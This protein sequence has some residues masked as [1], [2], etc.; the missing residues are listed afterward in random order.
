MPNAQLITPFYKD[1][2]PIRHQENV[3]ALIHN[4]QER[5]FWRIVLVVDDVDYT[6][7]DVVL[8]PTVEV[9][10]QNGRPT[11]NDL[12][13]IANE[14]PIPCVSIIAN[15]DIYFNRDS[16]NLI[17]ATIN[18]ETCFALSR[19]D[20]DDS[21]GATL[22]DHWDSQDAWVF[23]GAIRAI[24]GSFYLGKPGCDNAIAHR[25][26]SAGYKVTNPSK[27]IKSYHI[28]LS[29][30]RNYTRAEGEIIEK[31]YKL[32]NPT[33]INEEI[34]SVSKG[35]VRQNI[36]LPTP[37]QLRE[38]YS[39]GV[40]KKQMAA[41]ATRMLKPRYLLA[42][43]IPTMWSRSGTFNK[44]I[45]ELNCQI[46][47]GRF[48]DKVIVRHKVDGGVLPIGA[49]RND[50]IMQADAKYVIFMDDDDMPSPDYVDQL[51][52]AIENGNHP[53]CVT[54]ECNVYSCVEGH[55][56]EYMMRMVYDINEKEG[57][58]HL[59]AG[60]GRLLRK[61]PGHLCAIKRKIMLNVPFN[62]LWGD[63][64]DRKRRG[65]NGT[66]VNQLLDLKQSGLI[67]SAVHINKVLYHYYYNPQK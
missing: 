33:F 17:E 23:Y 50:L 27:S 5:V 44:L 10:Y 35:N 2:N 29:G 16:I 43:L 8:P 32:I 47:D 1:K 59:T 6:L 54:I 21:G 31:P 46:R 55:A 66:D 58:T 14:A 57:Q 4:I 24:D 60:G 48:G 52:S 34:L 22:Y 9:R 56:P 25:I 38:M 13:A 51:V 65:D 12:F 42:I 41:M 62:V 19:W 40:Q 30:Q 15:T 63:G 36:E 49:K 64:G 37:E 7:Q 67:K 28:H 3:A 20:V 26:E 45:Q 39:Y 11:Y 53:D 61:Y 18:S